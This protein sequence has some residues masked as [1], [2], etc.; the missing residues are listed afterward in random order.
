[1]V[2]GYLVNERILPA[3]ILSQHTLSMEEWEDKAKNFFYKKV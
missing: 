2:K 1:M 3:K